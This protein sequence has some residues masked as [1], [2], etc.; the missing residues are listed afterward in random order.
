MQPNIRKTKTEVASVIARL[1]RLAPAR[2]LTV[3][4]A[5]RVAELQA[6]SLLL[7]AG[8]HELP[9]PNEVITCQR[10]V[11]VEYDFD[12]P[13]SASGACHWDSQSRT[14]VIT[15]NASQ[16]HTRQRFT[17]LHE[18]KHILDHDQPELLESADQQRYSQPAAEFIADYFAGCTLMPRTLVIRAWNSGIRRPQD[19]AI[20]FDVSERAMEVRLAQLKLMPKSTPQTNSPKSYRTE[21][22]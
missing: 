4:E 22:A 8:V 6:T 13:D 19:L 20:R 10:R 9:V 5:R 11:M 14:W 17:L 12:M 16:S 2:P 21:A 3:D 15:I 7:S 18:Y 1:R